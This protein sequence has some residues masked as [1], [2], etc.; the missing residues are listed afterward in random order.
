MVLRGIT[1]VL[2]WYCGITVGITV[3]WVLPVGIT[4]TLVGITSGYLVGIS[5]YYSDYLLLLQ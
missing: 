5:G 1:V 4:V 3:Q 2:P